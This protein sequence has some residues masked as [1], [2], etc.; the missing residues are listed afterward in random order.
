MNTFRPHLDGTAECLAS[1][2]LKR[3]MAAEG[4]ATQRSRPSPLRQ[5]RVRQQRNYDLVAAGP[6]QRLKWQVGRAAYGVAQ[7]AQDVVVAHRRLAW[8][9]VAAFRATRRRPRC[10]Y[11]RQLHL[12]PAAVAVAKLYGGLRLQ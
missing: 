9:R 2:S 5:A 1:G 12:G 4:G 8:K 6:A 10:P 3:A 7:V 11:G